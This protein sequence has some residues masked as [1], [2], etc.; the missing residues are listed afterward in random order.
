[1]SERKKLHPASVLLTALKELKELIIPVVVLLFLGDGEG[2]SIWRYL[3]LAAIGAAVLFIIVSSVVRWWR[4][5]YWVEESELRIEYGLFVKKKRYI[6]IERIQSLDVSQGV[7]HQV[8][9]LMKVKVET[10]GS[11]QGS[12]SE[13]ELTAIGIEEAKSL[14]EAIQ[15]EKRRK[16]QVVEQ[17]ET[18]SYEKEEETQA[19]YR[20]HFTD[21]LLLAATSGG[22]GV[23]I[24]AAAAFLSQFQ[25]VIPYE[26]IF[27]EASHF[28]QLGAI[29]VAVS[30][31]FVLLFAWIISFILTLLKYANFTLRKGEED[32]IIQ[33]GLL[34]KQQM[35]IP[36]NRIQGITVIENPLRQM[37]GFCMVRL[38][39][40]GGAALEEGNMNTVIMP[41]IRKKK[42]L[43]MLS[44]LF[45]SYDF[46]VEFQGAPLR[47][48]GR[49]MIRA[50]L[51][52]VIPVVLVIVLLW[53]LGLWAL[54]ALL[55]AAA[56]GY[57]CYKSA[58]WHIHE[59]QLAIRSRSLALHTSF[60]QKNRI[61]SLELSRTWRQRQRE[62]A[63]VRATIK[64]GMAGKE[65]RMVDA[66]SSEAKSIYSWYGTKKRE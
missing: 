15:R 32:L 31:F 2:S 9:R 52:I 65:V 36:F 51:Y 12:K 16:K 39:S 59:G 13:A 30:A 63:T 4:F 42:A 29:F 22:V 23:V 38:E 61:Q 5:T 17:E 10:A 37:L 1:M 27:E 34:E 25:E 45:P 33:K 64:S 55:L 53:P 20:A 54:T 50:C 19:F 28:V 40:A 6:P 14:Q 56:Y 43:P 58:G 62:L 46:A 41:M 11:S 60:M 57:M 26:A 8:F 7:L 3:P 49:Y 44:E 66:S 47:A 18:S 48:A 35:T 21:L 24:S